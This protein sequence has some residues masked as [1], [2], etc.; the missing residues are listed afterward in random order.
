MDLK[1]GTRMSSAVCET[2]IVIVRPPNRTIVLECGGHP[3]GES[4]D[5]SPEPA[6]SDGTLL[7]KRYTFEDAALEVLCVKPGAGSLSVDG[8]AMTEKET[9]QL[10]SSD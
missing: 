8:A 9:K 2:Q 4:I 6:F 3:M 10:P 1:P 5:A 7:G